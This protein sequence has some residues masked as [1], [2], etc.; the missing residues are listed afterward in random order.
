MGKRKKEFHKSI[1]IRSHRQEKMF[2]LTGNQV[3]TW[4]KLKTLTITTIRQN[5]DPSGFHTHIIGGRTVGRYLLKLNI[6][7]P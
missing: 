7:T 2:S 3:I 5:V 6:Y 1:N 4:Q